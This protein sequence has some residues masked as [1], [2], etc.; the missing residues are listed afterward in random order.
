MRSA[1]ASLAI[2]DAKAATRSKPPA[3]QQEEI[4]KDPQGSFFFGA[5]AMRRYARQRTQGSLLFTESAAT[6]RW[7]GAK[8]T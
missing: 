1:A 2:P 8:G 7:T 5:L 4:E 3:I 6:H